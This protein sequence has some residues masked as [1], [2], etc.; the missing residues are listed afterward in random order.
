LAEVDFESLASSPKPFAHKFDA[1]VD[2]DVL[3]LVDRRLLT[4]R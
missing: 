1:T 3:D 2:P 4:H